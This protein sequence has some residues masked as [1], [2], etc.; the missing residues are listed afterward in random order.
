MSTV[1]STIELP[2]HSS[3]NAPTELGAWP[4]LDIVLVV[5]PEP[6]NWIAA[7]F[8]SATSDQ[9]LPFQSSVFAT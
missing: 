5:V 7:V 1:L 3:A 4:R 2:L 6:L 9:L 8:K